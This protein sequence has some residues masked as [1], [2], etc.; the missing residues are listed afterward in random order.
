[1]ARA[2]VIKMKNVTLVSPDPLII[3]SPDSLII[4]LRGVDFGQI[5]SEL[6]MRTGSAASPRMIE[7]SLLPF[8]STG[9]IIIE[10]NDADLLRDYLKNGSEGAFTELVKRYVDLVY[11]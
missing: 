7:L 8:A 4:N 9:H 2:S 11:A 3:V 5:L 10:M 6:L 1:M